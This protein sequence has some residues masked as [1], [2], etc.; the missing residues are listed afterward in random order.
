MGSGG[1]SA[2]GSDHLI[3]A[4][5]EVRGGDDTGGEASACPYIAGCELCLLQ[6]QLVG[7]VVVAAPLLGVT[8]LPLAPAVTST[9]LTPRYSRMRNVGIRRLAD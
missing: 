8:L 6:N 5:V 9:E 2:D 4:E 3:F 7:R 1:V